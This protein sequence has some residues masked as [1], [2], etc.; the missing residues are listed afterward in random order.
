MFTE[1]FMVSIATL[2]FTKTNILDWIA[3]HKF[4]TKNYHCLRS[5]NSFFAKIEG[6]KCDGR[7]KNSYT[8][9]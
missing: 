4:C 6:G 7:K 5:R 3:S 2:A 1:K 8:A 9:G